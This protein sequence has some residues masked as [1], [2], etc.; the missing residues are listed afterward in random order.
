M[1]EDKGCHVSITA[2][3]NVISKQSNTGFSLYHHHHRVA[4][5][6]MDIAVATSLLQA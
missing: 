1:N 3:C 4:C 5:L 2:V 6:L